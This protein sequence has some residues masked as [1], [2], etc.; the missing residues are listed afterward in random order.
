[1]VGSGEA[2][3][4]I[5][6]GVAYESIAA[7]CTSYAPEADWHF[8][9]AESVAAIAGSVD[10]LL[11]DLPA[12]ANLFIA[13]DDDA[14]NYAR[15]ELYLPAR[16]RGY[17]LQTLVH[18][19]ARVASD[20]RLADNVWVGPGASVGSQCKLGD[21]VLVSAGARLDPGVQIG[22]HGWVGVSASIGGGT[23]VGA[24]CVVGTDVH[25]GSALHLGRHCVL[26]RP[27]AWMRSM[28]DCT[29]F[30]PGFQQPTRMIGPGYS[31][32]PR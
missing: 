15:L 32:Q 5:G 7:D 12:Q 1:M 25:L 31:W 10:I 24:N 9:R 19:S 30:E 26:T 17:H 14:I 8:R 4:L 13:V 3:W 2:L 16:L 11:Q 20:A 18:P 27:G 21:N 29:F 22:S 23:V 6:C 28:S